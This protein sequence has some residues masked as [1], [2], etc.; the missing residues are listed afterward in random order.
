MLTPYQICIQH[1][2]AQD[3]MHTGRV[4]LKGV[5]NMVRGPGCLVVDKFPSASGLGHAPRTVP[6]Q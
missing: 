5:L 6:G 4:V 1:S 3:N 2:K